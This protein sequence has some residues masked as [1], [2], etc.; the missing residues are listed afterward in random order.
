LKPILQALLL[1][2]KIYQ[3][4][5]TGKFIIAGTFNGFSFKRSVASTNSEKRIKIVEGQ[6]AGSPSAFI[7]L[8]EV[9]QELELKLQY[10][11]LKNDQVM[12]E[13]K[14]KVSAT[15]PLAVVEFAVPLPKLPGIAGVHALELL[16]DGFP[17][18]ALR[19]TA[20]DVTEELL[21]DDAS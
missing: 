1:A 20:K 6:D 19:V 2:E 18:G 7:S 3:D 14:F 5:A 15:D 11:N 16:W 17:L 21:N 4:R 12:M 9:S 10:V 8:T 13:C